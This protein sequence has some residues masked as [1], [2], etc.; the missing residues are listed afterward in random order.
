MIRLGIICSI[1]HLKD[2]AIQSDFHLVLPH[3]IREYSEYREFYKERARKGDFVLLDNGVFELG[4]SVHFLDLVEITLENKFQEMVAPEVINDVRKTKGSLHDFLNYLIK[5][6]LHP[7]VL[8][9]I[10]GSTDI[11]MLNYAIEL[12][13]FSEVST[14]GIPFRLEGVKWGGENDPFKNIKSLTL[15]RVLLR[16][17]FLSRF[18]A[19]C[20]EKGIISKPIHLMGLSDGVELQMYNGGNYNSLTIRS[21][22]SS[23]AFVHGIESIRYEDKGLPVEKI[24]TPLDFTLDLSKRDAE[25]SRFLM[26]NVNFNIRMLK[27]FARYDIF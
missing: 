2:F 16:W 10:Q 22:D 6:D 1:P 12:Q 7:P 5:E 4:D 3:L 11:E 15:R 17:D 14:I 26:R 27:I 13:N 25:T 20:K 23:S 8:A 21:N 9:M 18:A 24:Q 19:A